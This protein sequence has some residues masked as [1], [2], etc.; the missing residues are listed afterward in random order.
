MTTGCALLAAT[1]LPLPI[2]DST[3]VWIVAVRWALV[4]ALLWAVTSCASAARQLR[5]Q[6]S[7][8]PSAGAAGRL[9]AVLL[10]VAGWTMNGSAHAAPAAVPTA[11]PTGL[12]T[13]TRTVVPA[14]PLLGFTPA[15][16]A[17]SADC[18][19][20]PDWLPSRPPATAPANRDPLLMSCSRASGEPAT[21]V[22]RRGDT[23]WSIVTR[24]LGPDADP[25]SVAAA[26]P[27][28][29]AINRAI[30]GDDPDLILVGQVLTVP[31]TGGIS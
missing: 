17:A 24:H 7:R 8:R 10:V 13:V 21:V 28:W 30:I 2:D 19:P 11:V 20:S 1:V 12:P 27:T 6:N 4:A 25:G 9:V 15:P 23:L 31:S 29:H 5:D 18:A 3:G 22:V 14:D 16:S 26:I